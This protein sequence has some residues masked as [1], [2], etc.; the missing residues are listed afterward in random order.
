V[1]LHVISPLLP[2]TLVTLWHIA[3]VVA[4]IVSVAVLPL[5]YWN[6]TTYRQRHARTGEQLA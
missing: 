5:S 3:S 4:T 6:V 1:S 2:N